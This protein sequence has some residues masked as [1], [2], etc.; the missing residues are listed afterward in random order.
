LRDLRVFD[1]SN[2]FGTVLACVPNNN[3]VFMDMD[4]PSIGGYALVRDPWLPSAPP[5]GTTFHFRAWL[6]NTMTDNA[7]NPEYPVAFLSHHRYNQ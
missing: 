1:I 5:A 4:G 7:D 3:T 6:D 2:D